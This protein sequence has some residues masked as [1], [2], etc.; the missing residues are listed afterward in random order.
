MEIKLENLFALTN[1]KRELKLV[2]LNTKIGKLNIW[3]NEKVK[4][5]RKNKWHK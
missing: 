5:M 2:I 1:E 3:K 4:K